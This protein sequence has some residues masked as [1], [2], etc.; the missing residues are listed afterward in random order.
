MTN[1]KEVTVSI[2]KY[3][4]SNGI[5]HDT[6]NGAELAQAKIDGRAKVCPSC[7]GTKRYENEDGRGYYQCN[8]CDSNGLVW[9]KLGWSKSS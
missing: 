1:I 5:N 2:K 6:F 4:D 9:L 8:S 7:N 3:Q